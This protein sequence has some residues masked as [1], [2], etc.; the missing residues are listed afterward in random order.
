MPWFKVDDQLHSHPKARRPSLAA[1]GLWTMCGS[2]CM[3]Y[4]TD[5]FVPSWFVAGFKNG[6]KLARE[7]VNSGLWMNAIRN[8]EEG[9]KFHDWTDWQPS[10]EEI[11]A[12]RKAARDRQ[13]AFRARRREARD[14]GSGDAPVTAMVTRDVTGDSRHPVQ[15]RPIPTRPALYRTTRVETSHHGVAYVTREAATA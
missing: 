5:G 13:R 4:K 8:S 7:L 14:N 15:S 2:Y 9:Y 1:I 6:P 3:A 12:E 11:E 10:S